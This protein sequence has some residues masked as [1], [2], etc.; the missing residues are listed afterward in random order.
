MRLVDTVQ[1]RS[2]RTL[3]RT[4]RDGVEQSRTLGVRER[5]RTDIPFAM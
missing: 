5:K 4:L 2:T 3:N 1:R